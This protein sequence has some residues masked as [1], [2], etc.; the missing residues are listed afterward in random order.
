MEKVT[1]IRCPRCELNYI[2]SNEDLCSV[3]QAEISLKKDD[4]F[5]D[6]DIDI[7]PVCKI[8]YIKS[9]EVMC[10][11]CLKERSLEDG[12]LSD[13]NID[14][15]DEWSSYVN[16]DD[17]D[18]YSSEEEET[19]EMASITDLDNGE[20]DLDDD[21]A[22]PVGIDFDEEEEIDET[23]S[24]DDK[25]DEDD[26][27]EDIIDDEDDDFDDDDFDEDDEDDDY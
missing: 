25:F 19:G 6:I 12:V 23:D 14:S 9:D 17:A 20:I 15:D 7:C 1:Y 11:T 21:L 8:N 5:D 16:R 13:E 18:E 24:D 3:C 26:D 10:L 22:I 27:F 4:D 2:K